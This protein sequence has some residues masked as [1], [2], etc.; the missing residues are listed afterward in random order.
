MMHRF[1]DLNHTLII[2]F[3]VFSNFHQL[4]GNSSFENEF[5]GPQFNLPRAI[6]QALMLN[7]SRNFGFEN[8]I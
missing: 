5:P 2:I 8:L 4:D 1:A 6:R 7:P 3:I